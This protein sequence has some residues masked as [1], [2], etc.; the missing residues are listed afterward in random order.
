MRSN[1]GLLDYDAAARQE[2]QS[3]E[4]E[5]GADSSL[6]VTWDLTDASAGMLNS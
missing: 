3:A 6:V 2:E 1:R 5:V 4:Q